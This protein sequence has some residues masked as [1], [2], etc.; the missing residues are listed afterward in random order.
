[1]TGSQNPATSYTSLFKPVWIIQAFNLSNGNN[2]IIA[3]F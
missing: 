3:E 2:R 1:V